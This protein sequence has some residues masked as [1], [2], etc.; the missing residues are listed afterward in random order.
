[1]YFHM[2]QVLPDENLYGLASRFAKLNGFVNHVQA[3]KKFLGNNDI[4]VA[5]ASVSVTKGSLFHDNYLED[6]QSSALT[7]RLLR[8]HLGGVVDGT[9]SYRTSTLQNESFGDV[10]HW[11][12]CSVCYQTD[13]EKYGVAYWHLEHQLPTTLVCLDHQKTLAEIPLKKKLIHDY[14]YLIDDV[15]SRSI[16]FDDVNRRH[17]YPIAEIGRSALQDE[18]IPLE[19]SIVCGLIKEEMIKRRVLGINNK[20]KI[21]TFESEIVEFFGFEFWNT[22]NERLRLK[23]PRYLVTEM[24]YGIEGRI[25]NRCI[26]IY[27]LFG[28]WQYFKKRCEWYAVFNSEVAFVRDIQ[29]CAVQT[30]LKGQHKC[31][32]LCS[33]YIMSTDNPNRLEFCRLFYSSFR[34]LLNNDRLWLDQK[35]P[36]SNIGKQQNLGF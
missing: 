12:Y 30:I 35:L 26:L 33:S 7:F 16:T 19:S 3:S 36:I 23:K 17:W 14:L 1:M 27:W 18:S 20:L 31:R 28:T 10:A 22:L 29:E 5:D 11:R 8:R 32:N 9:A 25:L 15:I 24:L 34:W 2:P 13:K 6:P 21:T 4:S